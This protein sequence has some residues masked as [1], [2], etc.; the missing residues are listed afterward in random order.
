MFSNHK[1]RE[2]LDSQYT[3]FNTQDALNP[4]KPDPLLIVHR[5]KNHECLAEI[6]LFCALLSY[7]N[8]KQIVK[9]LSKFDFKS[10]QRNQPISLDT[11]LFY[12]FQSAQ[13]IA[14]LLEI[15]RICAHK[16]GVKK[17]F[18][19]GYSNI[20]FTPFRILNGIYH[21]M[22]YLWQI[23]HKIGVH[24]STGLK[25]AL[26]EIPSRFKPKG[27]SA[28]KRWNLFARW[29]VR[30]DNIDLGLWSEI[31]SSDLLIPL[32]T[33]S[34]QISKALGLLERNIADLQ[35]VLEL[36]EN[37]KVFDSQDPIKYDFALYRI[38]QL[39]LLEGR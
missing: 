13:D 38:G 34:F 3:L 17:V 23:A 6:A 7:G 36:S 33:H 18:V 16:G 35:S 12:R 19:H 21:S 29:L 39:G 25:F 8:A 14:Y 2:F 32:D 1:L 20:N 24:K 15:L 31:D 11:R 26:G 30:K 27:Q 37:L 22:Y 9:F 4:D 5:F 10:L 28:L